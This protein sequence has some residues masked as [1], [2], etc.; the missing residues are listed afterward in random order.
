MA[1]NSIS[2]SLFHHATALQ[3]LSV[4]LLISSCKP[5][6]RWSISD[7]A[8]YEFTSSSSTN[9]IGRFGVIDE[10]SSATTT[11]SGVLEFVT[12]FFFFFSLFFF[13]LSFWSLTVSYRS[14]NDMSY[15]LLLATSMDSTTTICSKGV[16]GSTNQCQNNSL[17]ETLVSVLIDR[18]R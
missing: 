14:R 10:G 2:L 7:S 1:A 6:S 15:H 17:V 16:L 9:L 18:F 4:W 12:T 5:L 3:S 11:N 8:S 13:P